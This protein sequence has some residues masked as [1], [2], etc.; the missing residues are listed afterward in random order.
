M[1]RDPQG[2]KEVWVRAPPRATGG[3]RQEQGHP[4]LSFQ[5]KSLWVEVFPELEGTREILAPLLDRRGN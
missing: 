4:K 1:G 5:A 3:L 2:R